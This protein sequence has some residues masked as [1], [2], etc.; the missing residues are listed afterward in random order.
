MT[1]WLLPLATLRVGAA[2]PRTVRLTPVETFAAGDAPAKVWS[3]PT[4]S[5][6]F[7]TWAP[8]VLV[9]KAAV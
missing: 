8:S 3:S 1:V 7:C 9:F 4:L 5:E 2:W 6:K